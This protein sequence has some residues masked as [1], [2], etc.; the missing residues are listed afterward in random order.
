MDKQNLSKE[1]RTY[2]SE[3]GRSYSFK[4]QLESVGPKSTLKFLEKSEELQEEEVIEQV[5]MHLAVSFNQ[6]GISI[7]GYS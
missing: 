3:T 6:L 1:Y 4:I 7:I 5:S 2:N